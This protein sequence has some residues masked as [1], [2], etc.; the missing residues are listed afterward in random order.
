VRPSA[1]ANN[2]T[3]SAPAAFAS[4]GHAFLSIKLVSLDV[5]GTLLASNGSLP[6]ENCLAIRSASARGVRITLN[7]GKPPSTVI[8]LADQLELKDP[9]ITL[10]GAL[11]IQRT[12]GEDWRLVFSCPLPEGMLEGIGPA[13]DLLPLS[14]LV[15]CSRETYVYH[16]RRSPSYL[17]YFSAFLART[18]FLEYV[19]LERS[20]L[21][22]P[23]LIKLPILRVVFHSNEMQ[24]VERAYSRLQG[25]KQRAFSVARSSPGTIDLSPRSTGKLLAVKWLCQLYR[26]HRSEVMALG[27]YDTDLDLI[28]WAGIGAVMGNAPD[29]MKAQVPLVAP[30][31]DEGGV[32]FM[33]KRYVLNG[34]SGP[35]S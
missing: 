11:I 25:L 34:E 10:A 21:R 20:P 28:R 12:V 26:I 14:V 30:S 33:L 5:D 2:R 22:D 15:L 29:E 8:R 7:T 17:E 4:T 23:G 3:R 6:A 13:L 35:R 19:S 18:G 1:P 24:P 27:D 16:A 9:L 31:S 32:A